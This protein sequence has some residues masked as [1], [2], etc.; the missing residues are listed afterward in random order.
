MKRKEGLTASPHSTPHDEFAISCMSN[1]IKSPLF[2]TFAFC[3][4]GKSLCHFD[5][6]NHHKSWGTSALLFLKSA[7]RC[8]IS[9]NMLYPLLSFSFFIAPEGSIGKEWQFF[10]YRFHSQ[11][12][13]IG[14]ANLTFFFSFE[15]YQSMYFSLLTSNYPK[16]PAARSRNSNYANVQSW[17]SREISPLKTGITIFQMAANDFQP[18]FVNMCV[19]ACVRM[20]ILLSD[21]PNR[22]E[23]FV[24][25]LPWFMRQMAL[26]IY[27]LLY[28]WV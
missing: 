18:P 19:W 3:K 16:R 9:T 15:Q 23:S 14:N 12:G 7:L 13:K 17:L 1:F 2:T 10:L 25:W 28:R 27:E 11:C 21:L 8:E 6:P 22:S 20:H 24:Y 4:T 26:Q 5:K